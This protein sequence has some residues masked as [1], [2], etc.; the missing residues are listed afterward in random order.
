[1]FQL[2]KLDEIIKQSTNVPSEL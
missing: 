2:E 1:M